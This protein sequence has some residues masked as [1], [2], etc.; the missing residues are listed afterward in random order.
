MNIRDYIL[1]KLPEGRVS[2]SDNLNCRCPFHNDGSPSFSISL[3]TGKFICRSASCGI[4][5]S[6]LKFY[7]LMEGVSWKRA[8]SE[9]KT[10]SY[11]IDLNELLSDKVEKPKEIKIN[12]FPPENCLQDLNIIEYLSKRDLGQEVVESFGLKFGKYGR[13]DNLDITNSIVAPVFDVDRSYKTFQIRRLAG[14]TRWL[15]PLGTPLREVIYGGWFPFQSGLLWVVEGASD[16][17]NLYSKGIQSVGLFTKESTSSQYNRI[18]SLAEYYDLTPVVC[19]DG[20]AKES[21]KELYFDLTASG[22]DA[23][24]VLLR[25]HEDPGGLSCDRLEEIY[26]EL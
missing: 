15:N 13:F 26:K 12:Q 5:G 6:F 25:D 10:Q 8:I 23:K 24:L 3:D 1:K 11:E 2:A 14:K 19:L 4:R 18:I 7:K 16:V 17:W 22:L 9:L 21:S 20:D